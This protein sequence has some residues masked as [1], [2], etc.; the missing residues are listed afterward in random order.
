[1]AQ[2][3]RLRG[4]YWESYPVPENPAR[5]MLRH[6][7]HEAFGGC[8]TLHTEQRPAPWC[9][10]Y[11]LGYLLGLAALL[12]AVMAARAHGVT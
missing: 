8:P 10:A 12:M 2:L 4:S 6:T 9:W 11:R 1:M 7:L 5:C 3:K